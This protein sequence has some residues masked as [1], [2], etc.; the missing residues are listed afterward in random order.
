MFGAAASIEDLETE[1]ELDNID[2]D[3]VNKAKLLVQ[4]TYGHLKKENSSKGK[5]S[6]G[7]KRHSE[8]GGGI[9]EGG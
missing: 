1:A 8:S 3:Y 4:K 5:D 7:S 9:M 2:G 6:V